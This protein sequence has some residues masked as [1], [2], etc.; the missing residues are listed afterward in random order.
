VARE[1]VARTRLS[2]AEAKILEE[3]LAATGLSEGEYLRKLI[4]ERR[5][6]TARVDSI[7]ER[8]VAVEMY[9]A[10]RWAEEAQHAQDT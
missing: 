2:P 3:D 10:K 6:L 5:E 8:L 4:L 9:V 1:K 7:D